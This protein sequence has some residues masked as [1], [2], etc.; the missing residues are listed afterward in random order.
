MEWPN[1]GFDWPLPQVLHF[2]KK[3]IRGPLSQGKMN[4][5]SFCLVSAIWSP[6]PH[7]FFFFLIWSMVDLQCSVHFS[8]TAKC[9]S[10]T[11]ALHIIFSITKAK[12]QICLQHNPPLSAG[13]GEK[14]NRSKAQ[15]LPSGQGSFVNNF[16]LVIH[17]IT[18]HPSQW[19]SAVF[20]MEIT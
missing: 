8:Y 4:K 9:F 20:Q 5:F 13:E 7:T 12:E 11:S 3:Y 2:C 10:Y 6:S 19:R 18:I 17:V 1:Y 14:S 16:S 15:T